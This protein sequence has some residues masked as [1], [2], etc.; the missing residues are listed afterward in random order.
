M[1]R[2]FQVFLD[3]NAVFT[4]RSC[5]TH[6]SSHEWKLARF[7]LANKQAL[8]F[9]SVRNVDEGAAYIHELASVRAAIRVFFHCDYTAMLCNSSP[10]HSLYSAS[11]YLSPGRLPAV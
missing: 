4:C 2:H 10:W 1:G 5:S 7:M 9:R 8:L 3:S 6:V 11:L